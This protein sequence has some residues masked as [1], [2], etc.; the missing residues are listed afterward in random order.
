MSTAAK[1]K[2]APAKGRTAVEEALVVAAC[3][4]LAEEGPKAMSVRNVAAA[5]GVNHGQ[6]H[7]YFGGKRGL[8]TAA[9]LRLAREHFEHAN[10]RAEG[11][12]VPPP[13]T[14]GEDSD[15]W[16]A[17][18][19]LILDDDLEAATAEIDEGISVPR[20]VLT[21]FTGEKSPKK[22]PLEIRSMFAT[23]IALELGW[24][25]LE[26]YALTMSGIDLK[27]KGKAR[28]YAR[29]MAGILYDRLGEETAK[30]KK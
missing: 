13:L 26:S 11:N 3:K 15:Y 19:R 1:K 10:D 23:L 30:L 7:H 21:E 18:V 28:G 24:A 20:Q 8:I 14:L 2:G 25:S 6:V 12:L 22:I 4:M 16:H 17:L 9:V 29:E 27:D 5:A